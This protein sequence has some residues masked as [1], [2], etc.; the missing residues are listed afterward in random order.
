MADRKLVIADGHHRY[1]T[2]LAYRDECRA[3]QSSVSLSDPHEK[4]MMTFINSESEGLTIL[5]THRVLSNVPG[6]SADAL[7]RALWPWFEARPFPFTGS[8]ELAAQSAG[9]A[10]ALADAREQ[11]AIGLCASRK[12]WLLVLRPEMNLAALIPHVS[13]AQLGLDVVLLHRLILEKGLGITPEGV[14]KESYIRYERETDAAIAAVQD[15]TAQA[16]F[17]LNPVSVNQ[18]ME[19]ALAGEVL[20]QKSTDFYPKLLSGITIYRLDE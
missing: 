4:V 7:L 17:L 19:M 18:T 5:P 3:K 8:G 12:L 20:P 2:A 6:F 1:E 11:R 10:R 9:L 15:G 16:C 13:A 14:A